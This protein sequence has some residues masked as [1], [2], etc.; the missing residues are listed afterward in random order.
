MSPERNEAA[1]GNG[2]LTNLPT[3]Q[4]PSSLPSTTSEGKIKKRSWKD[5]R[6]YDR[7]TEWPSDA[8]D[9]KLAAD[10]T[11]AEV[12][13]LDVVVRHSFGYQRQDCEL[14][15]RFIVQLTGLGK[16][17][18]Q[19]ALKSLVSY[20]MLHQ[21]KE[22]AGRRPGSYQFNPNPQ[23]WEC[24]FRT[25]TKFCG[26]LSQ[27]TNSLAEPEK[28][29]PSNVIVGTFSNPQKTPRRPPTENKK[30]STK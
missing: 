8:L 11:K 30:V 27:P 2:D 16:R 14:A 4:G 12:L 5:T 23:E 22:P 26:H 3:D 10:L 1:G 7:W 29:L 21:T 19:K 18:V 6:P 24:R 15:S 17:H 25:G 9:A 28:T 20:R 13:V